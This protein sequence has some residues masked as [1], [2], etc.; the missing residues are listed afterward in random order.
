[1]NARPK[2]RLL[3]MTKL[4][5]AVFLVANLATLQRGLNDRDFRLVDAVLGLIFSG[6]LIH[7][8]IA[9]GP[10][11]SKFWIGFTAGILVVTLISIEQVNSWIATHE[12]AEG[13]LWPILET[14]Y[15]RFFP[16]EFLKSRSRY[17]EKCSCS[18]CLS[19]Y[20]EQYK[21]HY[22][23]TASVGFNLLIALAAGLA[24]ASWGHFQM[25]NGDIARS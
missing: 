18:S 20:L 13:P 2:A 21:D 23:R 15:R 5:C 22:L 11:H 10:V 12:G 6:L 8:A 14:P 17:F 7:L 24:V 9:K 1:M 16:Y 3:S 19:R 25:K 4:L